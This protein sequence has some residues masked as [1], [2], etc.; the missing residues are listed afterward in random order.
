M[1]ET[2]PPSGGH[3]LTVHHCGS[4]AMAPGYQQTDRVASCR[5]AARRGWSDLTVDEITPTAPLHR[6]MYRIQEESLIGRVFRGIQLE[7]TMRG[8]VV[9]ETLVAV[10]VTTTAINRLCRYSTS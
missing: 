7:C 4:V 2:L 3:S 6:E 8:R 10:M 9:S 1:M 5:A